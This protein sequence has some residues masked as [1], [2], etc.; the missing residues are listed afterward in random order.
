MFFLY[1]QGGGVGGGWI[2]RNLCGFVASFV[3]SVRPWSRRDVCWGLGGGCVLSPPP[4]S[5]YEIIRQPFICDEEER[6][7]QIFLE[8]SLYHIKPLTPSVLTPLCVK[9]CV[10]LSRSKTQFPKTFLLLLKMSC[11]NG[12]TKNIS[13]LKR[14]NMINV[15]IRKKHC[16]NHSLK[17]FYPLYHNL[18]G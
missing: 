14:R 18:G 5:W 6:I 13:C 4:Q 15:V 12:L 9:M 3:A 8:H 7:H 17:Q 2:S 16:Y 11:F 10:C 1:V